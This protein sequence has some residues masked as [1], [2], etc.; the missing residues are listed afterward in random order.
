MAMT[1]RKI[2][3]MA[4]IG[5][6]VAGIL[7]PVIPGIPLVLAGAAL[8]GNSHPLVRRIRGLLRLDETPKRAAS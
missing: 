4:L 3:G 8:L 7:V 2:G 5:L 1:F 6:G